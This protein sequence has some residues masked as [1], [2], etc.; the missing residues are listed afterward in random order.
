[1]ICSVD[2]FIFTSE[3]PRHRRSARWTEMG[4]SKDN[5]KDR[6]TKPLSPPRW[7]YTSC[8]SRPSTLLSV[9]PNQSRHRRSRSLRR[10][11]SRRDVSGLDYITIVRVITVAF[12]H[13]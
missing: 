12:P 5:Y 8:S 13:P 4:I 6:R 10:L 7:S 2:R 9:L 1:M 3:N 11:R